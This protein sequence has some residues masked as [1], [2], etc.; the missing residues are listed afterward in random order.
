MTILKQ[1]TNTME[2]SNLDN[3]IALVNVV[4]GDYLIDNYRLS[5]EEKSNVY[6][7]LG[8]IEGYAKM[9]EQYAFYERRND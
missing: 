6:R 3:A 2:N 5:H 1:S 8:L 4:L 9:A 7:A